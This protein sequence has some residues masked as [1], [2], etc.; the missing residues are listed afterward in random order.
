[1]TTPLTYHLTESLKELNLYFNIM[2]VKL[3]LLNQ[4]KKRKQK[5]YLHVDRRSPGL[6]PNWPKVTPGNDRIME[7]NHP[8]NN[9]FHYLRYLNPCILLQYDLRS[10][11]HQIFRSFQLIIPDEQPC[12]D[13]TQISTLISQLCGFFCFHLYLCFLFDGQYV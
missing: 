5:T 13:L 7:L 3:Y 4:E 12:F 10:T 11:D 8:W 6:C 2:N 1:M 9:E